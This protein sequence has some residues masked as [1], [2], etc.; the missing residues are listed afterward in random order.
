MKKKIFIAILAVLLVAVTCVSFASCNNTKYYRVQFSGEGVNI[1]AQSVEEGKTATPVTDPVRDD[2]NF[3]GWELDGEPFSFDTPVTK[4]IILVAKWEPAAAKYNVVFR[5]EEENKVIKTAVVEEGATVKAQKPAN[6]TRTGYAF[7]CWTLNGTEFDFDTPVTGNITLLAKWEPATTFNVVFR[8]EEENKVIKTAVVEEGATVK[9]Q[10][11]A[12]P[13]RTGYAFVCWTFNGTEFDFDTPVTGNITLLAKWEQNVFTVSFG[14]DG[15][16]TPAQSVP[17]GETAMEPASPTRENF[18]FVCWTLHGIEFD[19][20]TPIASDITLIAKWEAAI[21]TSMTGK[22]TQDDPYVLWT[23]NDILNFSARVNAPQVEANKDFYKSYFRLGQDIDMSSLASGFTPVGAITTYEDED[24]NNITVNAFFEGVFDGAGHKISNVRIKRA[25]RSG[26]VYAGFFGITNNATIKNVSFENI[27]Y[28]VESGA[29][30][31]TIGTYFGGVAGYAKKTSFVGVS[32]SGTLEARLYKAN[33]S[34]I[35]GLVGCWE[36]YGNDGLAQVYFTENCYANV[37]IIAGAFEDDDTKPTL[38]ASVVGG[39]HGWIYNSSNAASIINS[40]TAGEIGGGQAS[41][42]IV[43]Q[44]YSEGVSVINCISTMRVKATATELSSWAGGLIGTCTSDALIMDSV[45]VGTVS[46]LK[47][48]NSVYS[49]YMGGLIGYASSDNYEMSYSA[50]VAVVNSYYKA[51][52]RGAQNRNMLGT[53]L[54]EDPDITWAINTLNWDRQSWTDGFVPTSVRAKDIRNEATVTLDNA[55]VKTSLSANTAAYE[56]YGILGELDAPAKKAGSVFFDWEYA[57]NVRYR[58]YMPVFKNI[59]FTARWQDL[60]GIAGLYAGESNFHET[61]P[62]GVIQLMDDGTCKWVSS[63]TTNGVYRTDGVHILIEFFGST[64]DVSGTISGD[65]F[66]FLMDAGITGEIPYTFTRT[67]LKY[68]GEYYSATGDVITFS[69]DRVSLNSARISTETISGTFIENTANVLSVTGGALT[70]YF[71]SMTITVNEED[72]TV[73]LNFVGKNGVESID[74]VFSKM[75]APDYSDKPFVGKYAISYLSSSDPAYQDV[76]HICFYADGSAEIL[77]G[78]SV[79]RGVYY[80]FGN[81]LRFSVDGYISTLTYDESAD[82]LHGVYNR[83]AVRNVILVGIEDDISVKDTDMR[84]YVIDKDIRNVVFKY[85]GRVYLMK[86]GIYQPS[87]SISGTFEADTVVTIDG[88][89]YLAQ[90]NAYYTRPIYSIH[91]IG[92][93]AGDY[94]RNGKAL[95]LNGIGGIKIGELSGEYKVK[96]NLVIAFMDDD[97]L[98]AFDYTAAK[99]ADNVVTDV[100]GDEYRGVW[101]YDKT[102]K[103]NLWQEDGTQ[104]PDRMDL[105]I[106]KYYKLVLDGFG[107]ATLIYYSY[108]YQEYRYN[109]SGMNGT[110]WGYYTKNATGVGVDFNE[111]QHANLIFYYDKKVVYSRDFGYQADEMSFYKEGYNGSMNPPALPAE[112]VGSHTGEESDGTAVVFNLRADMT[113]TY[114]GEPFKSIYD[115]INQVIFAIDGTDYY[116]NTQTRVLKYGNESVALTL[117]GDITEVIPA[118]LCGEWT[119]KITGVGMGTEGA[120]C[121]VSI[122]VAG[123]LT[124][125][126][127]DFAASYDPWTNTLTA[128]GSYNNLDFDFTMVYNNENDSFAFTMM[129]GEY[130]YSGTMIKA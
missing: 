113:G 80:A 110:G 57:A 51:S 26:R 109:W 59:E 120:Q 31:D 91:V 96:G 92:A 14:G 37:N 75:G 76:Y 100:E 62:A 81:V 112:I 24:G 20:D 38:E 40:A 114:K 35:G 84:G 79:T 78:L 45:Y 98:F 74:G 28:I 41:G 127:H 9:A 6:P 16:N 130:S 77:T 27:H 64:G 1:P 47:P 33:A 65:T 46:A 83:G 15:V 104:A 95:T 105:F 106:K 23:A 125:D 34:A 101:Y 70:E 8:S 82:I 17:K 93:E 22:G 56:F 94:T 42:G 13:T 2:Y 3:V 50:G 60:S 49:S 121:T 18:R 129:R 73:T 25:A 123:V 117:G 12:N 61:R 71:S 48:T 30:V 85:N 108:D 72:F 68:F 97:E 69:N 102:V 5:S 107:G 55:G 99:A 53:E 19:F 111:T 39:L 43:G 21:P 128:S 88:V 90:Q 119:G 66:E 44:I 10:K 86:N 122:A 118:A 58:F 7:V 103:V 11:P 126:G 89:K 116:F 115:G 52:L 87:A 67:E 54:A 29:D 36:A 32:V 124:Y 63:S 4:D